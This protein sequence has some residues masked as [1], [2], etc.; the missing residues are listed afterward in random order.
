M[1]T[2]AHITRNDKVFSCSRTKMQSG[3]QLSQKAD[4]QILQEVL[5]HPE[6][7][8]TGSIMTVLLC[9]GW[10]CTEECTSGRGDS[11]WLSKNIK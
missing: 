3:P 1:R 10:L 2:Q 5:S 9:I 7:S 8:L 11:L 6:I 4:L